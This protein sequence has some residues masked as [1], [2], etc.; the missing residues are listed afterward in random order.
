MKK[1]IRRTCVALC[2]S[3]LVAAGGLTAYASDVFNYWSVI[4]PPWRNAVDIT[5]GFYSGKTSGLVRVNSMGG[6][7]NSMYFLFRAQ[8]G[9]I[10]TDVS[11][12]PTVYISSY[13][14][15]VL[16]NKYVSKGTR[17]MLVGGNDTPTYVNVAAQGEVMMP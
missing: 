9:D 5:D 13:Y 16:L 7:Y 6:G 3:L 8:H 15:S 10:W 14:S 12:A 1:S 4:L 11:S 17:L 2:A